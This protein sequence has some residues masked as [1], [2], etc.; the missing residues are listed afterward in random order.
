V[1]EHVLLAAN[2]KGGKQMSIEDRFWPKVD[3][4]GPKEC[5]WWTACRLPA[6]YG[7]FSVNGRMVLAHRYVY[8]LVYG[9]DPG[10]LQ[11]LHTCDNPSCCNPAHLF[12]GTQADNMAD[13]EAK[14]RQSR[15]IDRPAAKLTEEGVREA[16]RLS[17]DGWSQRKIADKLGVNQATIWFVLNGKTW[18]DVEELE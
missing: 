10:D 3:V 12:L 2:A 11:V 13:M 4:R 8:E 17:A 5:W 9:I 16:R 18:K 1:D 7:R 15:G 6:G 14:G